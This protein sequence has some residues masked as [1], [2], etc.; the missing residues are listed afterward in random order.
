MTLCV[1][2]HEWGLAHNPHSDKLGRGL[3]CINQRVLVSVKI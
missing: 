3:R 1:R 2:S